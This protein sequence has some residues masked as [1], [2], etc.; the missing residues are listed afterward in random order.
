MESVF[1]YRIEL[2]DLEFSDIA[3]IGSFGYSGVVKFS[4]L[5]FFLN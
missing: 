4:Y 1:I 2:A 5:P 3:E